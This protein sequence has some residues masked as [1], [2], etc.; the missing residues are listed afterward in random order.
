MDY[1]QRVFEIKNS[2]DLTYEETSNRFKVNI[3]TL[4]RWKKRIVPKKTRN[5][6][7]TKVDMEKL[8]KDIEKNP[9]AY[10][11]ERAQEFKV[12]T[13]TIFYAIKRLGF[14]YKKNTKSSKGRRNCPYTI[15]VQDDAI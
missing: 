13:S 14:S 5:K 2:E 6:P 3:R 9:D 15:P 7:A 8:K 4:F 12:G 10:L 1:R 11:Y